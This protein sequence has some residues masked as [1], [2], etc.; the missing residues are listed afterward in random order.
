[1]VPMGQEKA[2]TDGRVWVIVAPGPGGSPTC[3]VLPSPI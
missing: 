2:V 1:M 3:Q